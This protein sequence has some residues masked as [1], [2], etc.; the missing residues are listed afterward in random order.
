LFC[1]HLFVGAA[2]WLGLSVWVLRRR[3]FWSAVIGGVLGVLAVPWCLVRYSWRVDVLLDKVLA[4]GP[5]G[6]SLLDCVA[7]FGLNLLMA[8]VGA[9]LG[10][11][12]VAMETARLAIP[13]AQER[14]VAG[15]RFPACAP[16]V[17]A[18]FDELRASSP[19]NRVRPRRLA[20]TYG[21]PGSSWR[22]ALALTPATVVGARLDD[23]WTL[24]TSVPID[25]PPRYRLVFV[26]FAG[27]DLGVEEG[28]F[29][30][31]EERGWL[32][33]YTLTYV[34]PWDAPTPA[35]CEAWSVRVMTTL[36][37]Q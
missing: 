20:W 12:E 16:K 23:G 2:W 36:V 9:G 30:A 21:A 18:A 1:W 22:A 25:Y 35:V 19:A 33:P 31:L 15:G 13:G 26:S 28:L 34:T 29:H 37:G 27:V 4:H 6:L 24:R 5:D 7:V 8:V 11:P 10:F 3:P 14:D 32:H 17:A